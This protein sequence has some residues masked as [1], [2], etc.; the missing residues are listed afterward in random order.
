M[1][2]FLAERLARSVLEWSAASRPDVVRHSRAVSALATSVARALEREDLE[3]E[4][5]GAA[6]LLHDVGKAEVRPHVLDKA[7]PL[8]DDEWREVASHSL[9]GARLVAK[10]PEVAHL[11]PVVRGVHERW[12]GRGYPD[13]LRGLEIPAAARLIAI[14]DAYVAMTEVRPYTVVRSHAEAL[15]ELRRGAGSQFDPE[16]VAAV[17]G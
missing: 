12:D 6:A 15:D 13:G 17:V 4:E 14:V 7:G 10:M 8:D 9:R 2:P 16:L 1:S 11:A 5:I 3:P